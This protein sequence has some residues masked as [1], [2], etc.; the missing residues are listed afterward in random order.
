MRKKIFQII[1]DH[2]SKKPLNR[3][4]HTVLFTL[5]IISSVVLILESVNSFHEKFTTQFYYLEIFT[6]VFFS[7]EYILRVYT[8]VEINKYNSPILGRLRYILTP[9]MLIDLLSILP[10]YFFLISDNFTNFYIFGIFRVLRLFKAIRYINAFRIIGNVLYVKRE[11]LL[12]SFTLIF[13]LFV[14]YSCV[15]FIVENKAQPIAFKD[16]PSAMWFT[17]ST[18]TTVGFGDVYPVTPIGKVVTGLMSMSGWLMFAIPT[19]ILTSGFLKVMLY[20]KKQTCPHCGK[21]HD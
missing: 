16:I 12:I 18:I 7:I 13:F 17:I 15:I 6:I 21:Q 2:K 4:F 19:S 1:D 8:C 3:F 20:G 10:M 9:L 5:I 11:Q 14:F